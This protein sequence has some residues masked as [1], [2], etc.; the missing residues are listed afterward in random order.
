M[1]I[2]LHKLPKWVL[3]QSDF[4]KT[5]YEECDSSNELS[6]IP[7]LNEYDESYDFSELFQKEKPYIDFEI[8]IFIYKDTLK[9]LDF[10]GFECSFYQLIEP[11]KYEWVHDSVDERILRH[12]RTQIHGVQIFAFNFE[13]LP[14]MEEMQTIRGFSAVNPSYELEPF[15]KSIQQ[16]QLDWL[17]WFISHYDGKGQY[18]FN[19]L[20][21]Y[22]DYI[23]PADLSDVTLETFEWLQDRLKI[24]SFEVPSLSEHIIQSRN[25]PIFQK[26]RHEI[27][28]AYQMDILLLQATEKR[29]HESNESHQ[30]FFQKLIEGHTFTNDYYLVRI[31]IS[32]E[33]PLL[34]SYMFRTF[35]EKMTLVIT[36]IYDKIAKL[37]R[38]TAP[39]IYDEKCALFDMFQELYPHVVNNEAF[40]KST[41]IRTEIYDHQDPNDTYYDIAFIRYVIQKSE[42][43]FTRNAYQVALILHLQDMIDSYHQNA[44]SETEGS[45]D[46]RPF[47]NQFRIVIKTGNLKNIRFYIDNHLY[48]HDDE[49]SN[50]YLMYAIHDIRLFKLIYEYGRF[51]NIGDMHLWEAFR[52]G[53]CDIV[54]YMIQ[55]PYQPS[56]E[57]KKQILEQWN[58]IERHQ[59]MAWKDKEHKS[60]IVKMLFE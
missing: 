32:S 46:V 2:N 58:V 43:T 28:K 57:I 7:F 13:S 45:Y 17:E 51:R 15:R 33:N 40:I 37:A 49:R 48:I 12:L 39:E 44:W 25:L 55:R 9:F 34:V 6:Y 52:R 4:L 18:G 1:F 5:L 29:P 11:K 27:A 50:D 35:H 41:F 24:H 26:Y 8:A 30:N 31:S 56:N 21:D 10:I 60:N 38:S 19:Q 53:K 42:L 54:A 14:K 36:P 22:I 23:Y 47:I 3:E 20:V 59:M 16:N